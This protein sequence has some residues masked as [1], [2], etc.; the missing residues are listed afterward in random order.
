MTLRIASIIALCVLLSDAYKLDDGAKH[1]WNNEGKPILAMAEN[2]KELYQSVEFPA[3]SLWLGNAQDVHPSSLTQAV[4][5]LSPALKARYVVNQ[6][7]WAAV[8]TISTRKDVESYPVANLISIADGPVGSGTGVPYIYLTPLDYTGQDL[9]KDNR[10]TLLVTLAQGDYCKNKGYD[11]MDPRCV[12]V[13]LT[14]KIV[15]LKN[16]TK[17]HDTAKQLFFGRHPKLENMPANHHFYF[18]ELKISTIAMLDH[19]GGP[20]Y[21]SVDDYFNPSS[22]TSQPLRNSVFGERLMNL[23]PNAM[24]SN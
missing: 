20:K 14:G 7:D 10:A 8:A 17:E 1:I 19:F 22:S 23:L 16:D 6:A 4:E 5:D 11:P 21:I 15:V 2:T 9:D 3:R 12:R 24:L 13:M 18:A